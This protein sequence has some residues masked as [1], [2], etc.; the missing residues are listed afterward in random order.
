MNFTSPQVTWPWRTRHGDDGSVSIF[1]VIIALVVLVFFG[2]VVDFGN[3]LKA[4]Q[5]AS[6]V[7]QEA[8]RAGA[9]RVDLDRAYTQ[10]EFV[11]DRPSAVRAAR[12]YLRSGGYT[13]TVTASGTHSIRV[14]VTITRPAIFLPII[15][16][17]RLRADAAATAN[18]TTGVRGPH[19]P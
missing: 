19:R 5:V 6:V 14:H 1:A 9:G 10:G 16:V 3:K 11:V 4:R 15:G 8:A 17:T 2:A 12:A 7:A 13:G 18:L